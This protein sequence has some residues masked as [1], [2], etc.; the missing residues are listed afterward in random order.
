MAAI[1]K[2]IATTISSSI[3]EKPWESFFMS[4]SPQW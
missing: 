1:I 2:M 4:S 3:N